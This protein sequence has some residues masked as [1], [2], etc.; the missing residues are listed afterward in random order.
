MI[1]SMNAIE[2]DDLTKHFDDFTAVNHL[3]FEVK[4]GEI[5]GFLGQQ[6]SVC[7]QE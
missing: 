3:D 4:K 6:L 5:L 1:G 7:S 2:V